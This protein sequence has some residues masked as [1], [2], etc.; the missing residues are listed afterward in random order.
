MIINP[1]IFREYDIRGIADEDLKD[2][3]VWH[4]GKAIAS[5]IIKR[6]GKTI[7]LGR[8]ARLSSPRIHDVILDAFLKSGVNVIDI[9]MVPTPI[10][11]FS[12]FHFGL[13]GGIQITGSHNPK[14]FNGIKI[15][16]GKE[17]IHG[18]E[19]QKI[20]EIIERGEYVEG[21]GK[22]WIRGDLVFE[23]IKEVKER[24]RIW[25]PESYKVAVDPGNGTCG[26]VIEGLY[27]ELKIKFSGIYMEPNGNFPN[28]LP[29]PT[30]EK[31]MEDL[32]GLMKEEKNFTCGFGFDGDGDRLGVIDDKFRIIYGD[33]ILAIL[34]KKVLE[35]KKGSKIIF[36]VKCSQGVYEYIRSIGGEPIMWKTGHSLI[37]AKLKEEGAPIAGEMSGHL[38]FS[39][40]FYGFDDAIYAS[41][42]FLEVVDTFKKKVHEL[43]D[44]IP[45][46]YSTPEI[47]VECPDEHKFKVVEKLKKKFSK[48]FKILDIDGVRINFTDG[49]GLVRASN[50][51]PVL[52]LRFEGKTP[53]KMEEIKNIIL[54]ELS[55]FTEINLGSIP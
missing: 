46:Y 34:S 23:Y 13:D 26:P 9:G 18:K 21:H 50:T 37:K 51:Q 27:N 49:F 44:E 54:E 35:E 30:V 5:Y 20:R 36:D 19:I 52:V 48:K 16:C 32:K 8:D 12:V 4:I 11:Y 15:M 25:D 53:E 29:D 3:S 55:K 24:V 22:R 45:F 39:D 6:G 43:V 7:S 17:T 38:F 14:E 31:Y 1:Y 47:R 28:H 2:E 41:L 40:R 33:K 42:R 10:L